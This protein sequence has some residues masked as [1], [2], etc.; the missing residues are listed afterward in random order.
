MIPCS[1]PRSLTPSVTLSLA[2]SVSRYIPL[3]L[4]SLG[5]PL[6][7]SLPASFRARAP[8]CAQQLMRLSG[9]SMSG[10]VGGLNLG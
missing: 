2:P 8:E 4:P 1:L 10:L 6:L 9:C 7:R 5:P 3:S